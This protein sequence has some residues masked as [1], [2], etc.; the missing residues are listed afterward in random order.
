MMRANP[1]ESEG[2]EPA[3]GV[4]SIH[5]VRFHEW[6]TWYA[7]IPQ[8]TLDVTDHTQTAEDRWNGEPSPV[9]VRAVVA[10]TPH[11]HAVDG[12]DAQPNAG[13]NRRGLTPLTW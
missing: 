9:Q 7:V 12:T 6:R 8:A 5:V 1:T 2:S 13:T 3:E 10:R 11:G 4:W